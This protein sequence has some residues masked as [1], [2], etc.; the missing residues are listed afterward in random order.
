MARPSLA[1]SIKSR[2]DAAGVSYAAHRSYIDDYGAAKG[3]GRRYRANYSYWRV[4]KITKAAFQNIINEAAAEFFAAK[5]VR[6]EVTGTTI[7]RGDGP[8]IYY[9]IHDDAKI[10][11]GGADVP[12]FLKTFSAKALK[13]LC[14]DRGVATYGTRAQMIERLTK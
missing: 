9:T 14:E 10:A 12:S 4:G 3:G 13:A 2:L 5:G 1:N 8:H 7:Y 11:A 6:G